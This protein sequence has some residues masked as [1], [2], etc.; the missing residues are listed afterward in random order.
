MNDT[1]I[2]SGRHPRPNQLHLELADLERGVAP[3]LVA[4]LERILGYA[5]DQQARLERQPVKAVHEYR[6]SIR[7]ARA[8][9]RLI[10]GKG[11]REL[12]HALRDVVRAT[13]VLRD[14]DVL[15]DNLAALPDTGCDLAPLR[16]AIEHARS[17]DDPA[18]ILAA[19][20]EVLAG[21]PA[22][23]ALDPKLSLGDL[24]RCL[25]AAYTRARKARTEAS[26]T[27]HD[28]DVHRWRKRVKELRYQLELLG[29]KRQGPSHE[30]HASLV[31]QATQ[32]GE[33]TDDIVMLDYVEARPDLHAALTPLLEA[34]QWRVAERLT[35]LIEGTRTYYDAS[36]KTFARQARANLDH[37]TGRFS[38]DAR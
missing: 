25:A 3:A 19:G 1:P 38:R 6:K 12:D 16:A 32:L 36:P 33:V 21:V 4:A 5:C 29:G 37:A 2:D 28:D 9:L 17:G 31:N 14:R 27:R 11:W 8:L 34:L 23:W 20:T 35:L 24:R 22:R 13:S 7:R 30:L 18:P 15:L 26:R 10:R